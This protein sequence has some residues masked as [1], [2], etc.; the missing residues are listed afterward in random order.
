MTQEYLSTQAIILKRNDLNDNDGIVT[1]YTVEKGKI[2]AVA[3]GIKKNTSKLRG[4]LQEFSISDITLV[5]GKNMPIIINTEAKEAFLS[6]RYDLLKMS[7]AA[8]CV[9]FLD[10]ILPQEEKDEEIYQLLCDTLHLI[11]NGYAWTSS[12]RFVFY[13]LEHMGYGNNKKICINC[14][15]TINDQS[16]D[17]TAD[18]ILCQ[19]CAAHNVKKTI[20]LSIESITI[21]QALEEYSYEKLKL[22]YPSTQAKREIGAYLELRISNLLEYPLKSY[23][24]LQEQ[25]KALTNKGKK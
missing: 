20:H 17:G 4:G 1:L 14:G 6:I 2:N 25:E 21:L 3:K 13:L 19:R 9:D 24:F 15:K 23:N 5:K 18:G 12:N 22:I 11:D 8:F 16:A 7:Y 10:K